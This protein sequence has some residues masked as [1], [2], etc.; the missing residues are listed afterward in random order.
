MR[1]FL[2]PQGFIA[3]PHVHPKQEERF[4]VAGAPVVFKV[5]G[6]SGS[7]SRAR[8][9]SSRRARRTS[10]GTPAQ[11]RPRRSVQ[12]RPALNTETFFETFFGLAA[13]GKV[14]KNGLPNPLH[15]LLL[16]HEYRREM[17]A[18][19]PAKWLIGP[20]SMLAAPLARAL[21]YRGRYEKYSDAGS[22][23]RRDRPALKT[24]RFTTMPRRGSL[25]GDRPSR[26]PD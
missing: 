2:A 21:G 11:R 19:A 24:K 13:D 4:D 25:T 22:P 6:R 8:S 15:M 14:G 26:L 10:G 23:S 3:A 9:S 20:L 18:P 7:T 12:F 17:Q 1:L 16:A 5:A